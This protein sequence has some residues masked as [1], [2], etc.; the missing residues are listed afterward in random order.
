MSLKKDSNA[1]R[2]VLGLNGFNGS[3]KPAYPDHFISVWVAM[4]FGDAENDGPYCCGSDSNHRGGLSDP[5]AI[6]VDPYKIYPAD[7]FKGRFFTRVN[8]KEVLLDL[9]QEIPMRVNLALRAEICAYN[10]KFRALL[11]KGA[12]EKDAYVRVVPKTYH[13][14]D[15]KGSCIMLLDGK[16]RYHDFPIR[17]LKDVKDF[18]P[19]W[20]VPPYK[21]EGGEHSKIARQALRKEQPRVSI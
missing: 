21:K 11:Q 1:V 5:V 18:P 12:A 16:G 17:F 2:R 20:F 8:G 6:M 15:S 4:V 3:R 13:R 7:R 9:P 14:D 10:P 19:S